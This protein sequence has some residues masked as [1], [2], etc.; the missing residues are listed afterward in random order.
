MTKTQKKQDDG[1]HNF[2]KKLLNYVAF[3]GVYWIAIGTNLLMLVGLF[4]YPSTV[5]LFCVLPYYT[6]TLLLSR[7][8][9][10]EGSRWRR[11]SEG[12]F[13]FQ[14]MRKYLRIRLI[15]S[16]N[17]KQAEMTENAQFIFAMFPHGTASD[18]RI[19]RDGILH[20]VFPKTCKKIRALAAS[21]L[22]RIPVVR[23]MALWTGCVDASRK[24]AENILKK[25]Y[26]I[27]V[28]PGGEAEQIRTVYQRERIYLKKRKGFVKLAM[29]KGVPLVP[30]Y[31]FGASDYYFTSKAF[32]APR[33]WLQKKLGVCI[34][35]A[36]GLWGSIFVPLPV[37]TTIVFGE[38][39]TFKMKEE[40][41]PTNE[42]LDVAHEEFC[43]ALRQLFD[44]H[45]NDLGYGDRELEL[46]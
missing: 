14:V 38:P 21:V 42:E 30:S 36:V 28:L 12:F 20:T 33:S 1:Q 41:A 43:K 4:S 24:V 29:R 22:F 16:K 2:A 31:V 25:G 27:I 17:L 3:T 26:S 37:K 11:F 7:S 34:P 6:F 46:I 13:L 32:F 9:M 15:C 45:K 5:G 10:E 23:E 40:G 39:L 35:L 44:T 18:Y 19:L 8:E